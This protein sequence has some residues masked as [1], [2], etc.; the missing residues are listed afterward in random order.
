[1]I[2]FHKRKFIRSTQSFFLKEVDEYLSLYP[3]T[4]HIDICLH[5]LNGH[6]RGKRIDVKSLKN[7]SNDVI[8]LF[9]FMP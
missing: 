9:L 1:M 7:L 8:F 4:Q 5:D 2:L 3:H 6:I